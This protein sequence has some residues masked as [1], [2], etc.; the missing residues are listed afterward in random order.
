MHRHFCATG[1]LIWL[2][3]SS[4][5]SERVQAPATRPARPEM[6][7]PISTGKPEPTDS[8]PSSDETAAKATSTT[9]P[10]DLVESNWSELQS[11]IGEKKGKIVVVDIW[12]TSCEPCMKELPHLITLQKKY[13]DDVVAITF[14]IDYVGIK[15]KPPTYYRERVLKVLGSQEES[16]VLHRMCTTAAEDFFDE[17]KLDSIPSVYVYGRDGSSVKRFEGST[18]QANGVSY[19]KRVI[20]FVDELVKSQK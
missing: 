20:P 17:I 7:P 2:S 9:K 8:P 6:P 11:L 14:D 16:T 4:G 5:C 18:E 15:N 1:V 10:V 3:F 19:E 13:P 12:S